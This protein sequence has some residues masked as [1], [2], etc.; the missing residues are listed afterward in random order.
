MDLLIPKSI[1]Q[2]LIKSK[3]L[4]NIE[5]FSSIL[6]K[7]ISVD[8]IFLIDLEWNNDFYRMIFRLDFGTF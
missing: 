1:F 7:R 5:F 4:M 6:K 3:N 8:F 2:I